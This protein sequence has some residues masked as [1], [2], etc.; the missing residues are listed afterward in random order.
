MNNGDGPFRFRMM[1]RPILFF[2]LQPIITQ[3]RQ[4]KRRNRFFHH[5]HGFH[6]LFFPIDTGG[7]GWYDAD[8]RKSRWFPS[9]TNCFQILFALP[10]RLALR[11]LSDVLAF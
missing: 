7:R 3:D 5:V 9:V 4:M 6:F 2:G 8:S 11:G 1:G 10:F